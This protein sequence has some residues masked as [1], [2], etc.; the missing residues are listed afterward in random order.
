[1]VVQVLPSAEVWSWKA[2]AYA[3]S[4]VSTTRQMVRVLPRSTRSHC[5]SLAAL[6]QRVP[7]LPS[8]A[9]DAAR[10]ASWMDEAVAGWLRAAL[11]LP[12]VG[13]PPPISP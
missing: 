1:M 2:R 13:V 8:T 10:P 3:A 12:Q 5:G 11:A 9:A 7:A 6:A 4:Q